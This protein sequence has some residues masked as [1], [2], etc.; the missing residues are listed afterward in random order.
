MQRTINKI[1]R[2]TAVLADWSSRLWWI[3]YLKDKI[4]G[5]FAIIVPAGVNS[6]S[7]SMKKSLDVIKFYT[8]NVMKNAFVFWVMKWFSLSSLI[9]NKYSYVEFS[10]GHKSLINPEPSY[11]EYIFPML[12]ELILVTYIE[13]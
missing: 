7:S 4:N 6:K 5:G 9:W 3:P 1:S 11:S 2:A 10:K 13:S 8:V 12:L